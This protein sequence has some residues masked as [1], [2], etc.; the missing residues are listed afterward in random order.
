DPVLAA[1]AISTMLDLPNPPT[2]VFAGNNMVAVGALTALSRR[3][4]L[5]T[6][7]VV[8]FDDLDLATVL[9]PPLTV[10]EQDPEAI[11]R[12]AAAEVFGWLGGAVPTRDVVVPLRLIERGSGEIPGPFSR[13]LSA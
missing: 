5:R 3:N 4:A 2:A 6:I 7:A 13:S 1:A 11:G 9:D 12:I 8:G 10:I